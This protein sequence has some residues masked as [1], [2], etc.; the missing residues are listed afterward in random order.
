[1]ETCAGEPADGRDNE[2]EE[3]EA[4]GRVGE[5]EESRTGEQAEGDGGG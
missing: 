1:M 5:P 3:G 2:T 4:D